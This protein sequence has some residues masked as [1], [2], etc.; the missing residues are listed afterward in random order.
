MK[1][2]INRTNKTNINIDDAR[3]AETMKKRIL[4]LKMISK[5]YTYTIYCIEQIIDEYIFNR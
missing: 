4:K 1:A 2:I 3:I 5:Y